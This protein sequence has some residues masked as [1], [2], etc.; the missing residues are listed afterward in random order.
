MGW[1]D[2]HRQHVFSVKPLDAARLKSHTGSVHKLE[3]GNIPAK[4]EP[5]FEPENRYAVSPS[6]MARQCRNKRHPAIPSH[7]PKSIQYLVLMDDFLKIIQ[8]Q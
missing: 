1:V 6:G 3:P 8:R 4:T 7:P 5:L 2:F